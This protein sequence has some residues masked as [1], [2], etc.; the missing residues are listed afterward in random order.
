MTFL[1][2]VAAIARRG[3]PMAGR[4]GW[5]LMDQAF[6]SL[7]N[8]A[9][10]IIV[11]RNVPIAEFG[12]FSLAIAAYFLAVNITRAFP[13]Q[14][15]AIRYSAVM[16]GTWRRGSAASL[17]FVLLVGVVTGLGFVAVGL[18]LGGTIGPAFIAIGLTMP[19]LLLQDGWRSAF[20]AA[21]KGSKAFQNDLI[22]AC[23]LFPALG[24][25]M[26]T[27]QTS[28]FWLTLAWGGAATIAAVAGVAQT[29]IRP[30]PRMAGS[31]W[32][33]HRDLGPRY[34]TEAAVSTGAGQ[35]AFYGVG[36]VAGL[37]SVGAFRAAQLMFGPL[38]VLSLGIGL[39]AV[40]EG[41]RVMN[42]SLGRLERGALAMSAGLAV[43]AVG[44]GLVL[45]L[46]PVS[47]GEWL[48]GSTWNAAAP[49]F[50]PLTV[51]Y[52][53][54]LALSGPVMTLRVVAN[55]RRSL[56][57][58]L[59]TSA[60]TFILVVGG[61]WQGAALGAAWGFAVGYWLGAAAWWRQSLLAIRERR[62]ELATSG[63]DTNPPAD[64]DTLLP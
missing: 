27:G 29:R 64:R 21:G 28:V 43:V 3:R 52:A 18:L 46:I 51:A 23:T 48:M 33:E 34:L 6:S 8:F 39:I 13:M 63:R 60:V 61:A 54:A 40:P 59:L 19:G 44:W 42:R 17:G 36:L 35:L 4:A 30:R 1:G 37:S 38:Q 25:L 47:F 62:V 32:R 20:F 41:V 55:A 16:P 24:L 14:P 53:G 7:T 31:W 49:L 26:A 22:W 50:V 15:L 10:G 5:G 11:A 58:N 57:A 12:A 56:R 45:L 9:L 2:D